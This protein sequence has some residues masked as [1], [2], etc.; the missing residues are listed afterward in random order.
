MS[1]YIARKPEII[2][3]I[4]KA[5]VKLDGEHVVGDSEWGNGT[6]SDFVFE[7]KAQ[8]TESL[9]IIVEF[10]HTVNEECMRRVTNYSL[11]ATKRC[12]RCPIVLI[13][14]VNTL[15]SD[16]NLY[17]LPNSRISSCYIFPSQVWATECFIL[18]E[19]S[20]RKCNTLPPLDPFVALGLF[21]TQQDNSIIT[22]P[23]GDNQT[24][25]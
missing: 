23:C 11:E 4:T 13:V 1:K 20:L 15:C 24:V 6:R 12:N 18:C 21:L 14:C 8:M 7:P 22:S 25:K 10:Q 19:S 2:N 9:P 3:I 17:V 16:I 5:L